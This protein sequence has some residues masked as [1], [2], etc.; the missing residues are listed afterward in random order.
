MTGQDDEKGNWLRHAI[1]VIWRDMGRLGAAHCV[2]GNVSK[3]DEDES[4]K[5][6]NPDR[7]TATRS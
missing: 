2:Y 1:V 3:G 6:Q 7:S 4:V 5:R